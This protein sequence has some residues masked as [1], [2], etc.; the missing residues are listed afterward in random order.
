MIDLPEKKTA[1]FSC[2]IVTC[3]VQGPHIKDLACHQ[4]HSEVRHPYQ[5]LHSLWCRSADGSTVDVG[6][7]QAL[8]PSP[9][10]KYPD[11]RLPLHGPRYE[12]TY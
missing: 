10:P 1:R 11:A 8:E 2:W 6:V 3:A 4:R 5:R 9:G 7:L 12:D